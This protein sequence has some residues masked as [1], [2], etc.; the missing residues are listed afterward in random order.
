MRA[1]EFE[2][3]AHDH[4]VSLPDQIPDG[5]KLRVLILME[6]QPECVID[7]ELPGFDGVLN[8]PSP[9][10]AGSVVMRDDL[11]APAMPEEAWSALR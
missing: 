11:L 2:T 5:V 10:L 8:K 7:S 3:V 1:I 9:K 6:E 4:K